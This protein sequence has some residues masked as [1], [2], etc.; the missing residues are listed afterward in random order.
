LFAAL[1]TACAPQATP[2]PV[3]TDEP[4]VSVDL[5][6]DS[7]NASSLDDVS[8]AP[9]QV[10][11][12]EVVSEGSMPGCTVS[13]GGLFPEREEDSLFRPVDETDWVLGKA[14]AATTIIEYGDFQ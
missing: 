14:T 4:D 5:E 8:A 11:V 3:F 1:L 13:S 10:P 9:T 12:Q 2:T 7:E 6:T